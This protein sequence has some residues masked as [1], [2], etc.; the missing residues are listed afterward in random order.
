MKIGPYK[1]SLPVLGVLLLALGCVVLIVASGSDEQR[2]ELLAGAVGIL[3]LVGAFMRPMLTRDSDGDGVPDIIDSDAEPT[4][5]QMRGR[6]TSVT[7]PPYDDESEGG[8][9]P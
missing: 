3:A 8:A 2:Q 1:L 6:I 5:L 4:A 9:E 7:R